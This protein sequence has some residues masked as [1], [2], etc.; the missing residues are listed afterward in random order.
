MASGAVCN[1]SFIS[2]KTVKFMRFSMLVA[3]L[4]TLWDFIGYDQAK[5]TLKLSAILKFPLLL[6]NTAVPSYCPLNRGFTLK[7]C[8]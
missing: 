2:A 4:A 6:K 8:L 7:G 3:F 1:L 5:F